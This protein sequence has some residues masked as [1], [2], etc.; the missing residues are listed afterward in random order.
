MVKKIK[1][2]KKQIRELKKEIRKEIS[3]WLFGQLLLFEVKKR[4]KEV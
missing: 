1:T 2:T 4:N 3:A